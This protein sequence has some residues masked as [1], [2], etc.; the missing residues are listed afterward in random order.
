MNV[1]TQHRTEVKG[2]EKA[3]RCHWENIPLCVRDPEWSE[4][5]YDKIIALLR[6]WI[7]VP[8]SLYLIPPRGPQAQ[9]ARKENHYSCDSQSGTWMLVF[10][11][12]LNILVIWLVSKGSCTD[13]CLTPKES[14]SHSPS[15]PYGEEPMNRTPYVP[16]QIPCG[17]D[18]QG[19]HT[20]SGRHVATQ[21][22]RKL[23]VEA[24]ANTTRVTTVYVDGI[25]FCLKC[26]WRC[27]TGTQIPIKCTLSKTGDRGSA[28]SLN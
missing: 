4:K 17:D 26:D 1:R 7:Q 28:V 6:S 27:V 24:F 18:L 12:F 8:I 16:K 10:H 5:I 15:I 11:Y 21:Q 2:Q 9:L 14:N 25:T 23:P 3:L 19:L 22:K 20:H 13:L